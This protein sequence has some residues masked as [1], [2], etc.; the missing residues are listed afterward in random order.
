MVLDG[1]ASP[2][3]KSLWKTHGEIEG[4][5]FECPRGST[6]QW[7]SDI[8]CFFSDC[9]PEGSVDWA[10]QHLTPNYSDTWGDNS[11]DSLPQAY[12]AHFAHN[13]RFSVSQEKNLCR[14]PA[15]GNSGVATLAQFG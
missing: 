9:F 11:L 14:I 8:L 2:S 7:G 4:R 15:P 3:L 12:F 13:L 6:V 10:K 5:Q 1:A